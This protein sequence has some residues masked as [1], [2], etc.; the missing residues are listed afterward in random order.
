MTQD[1]SFAV[2]RLWVTICLAVFL[3]II[4]MFAF[5]FVAFG[6]VSLVG[7]AT[8]FPGRLGESVMSFLRPSSVAQSLETFA[9]NT[10]FTAKTPRP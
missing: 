8:E 10:V 3:A 5:M 2:D 9:P 4:L 7:F 6:A 1:R